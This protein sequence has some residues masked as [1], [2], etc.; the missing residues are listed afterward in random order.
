MRE[1]L[2][3]LHIPA[4]GKSYDVGVPVGLPM[5]ALAAMLAQAAQK[6]SNGR[7][8]PVDPVLSSSDTGIILDINATAEELNLQ[9][10]DRL[11]LI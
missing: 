3:E 5:H 9:T 11:M 4:I 1:L 8:L 10:G 2:L 7:F 6:L